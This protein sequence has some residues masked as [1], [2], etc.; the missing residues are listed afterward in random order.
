M[1][2]KQQNEQSQGKY[3]AGKNKIENTFFLN[4]EIS[5]FGHVLN[6]RHFPI[7]E[8]KVKVTCSKNILKAI[9]IKKWFPL[10]SLRIGL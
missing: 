8:M 1:F 10:K 5:S 9:L 7:T 2:V 4:W 3:N 6:T